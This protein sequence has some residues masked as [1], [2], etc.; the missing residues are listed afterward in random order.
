LECK[1]A[2]AR[3]EKQSLSTSFSEYVREPSLMIVPP[4]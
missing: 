3:K 4:T 2:R 1:E